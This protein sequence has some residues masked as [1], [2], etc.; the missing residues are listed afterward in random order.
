M[1][2]SSFLVPTLNQFN[3]E[4]SGS[5]GKIS[6]FGGCLTAYVTNIG[7]EDQITGKRE[8]VKNTN[9]NMVTLLAGD[10]L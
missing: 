7:Q 9:G 10:K 2:I 1:F 5:G 3:P 8:R 6:G 4:K